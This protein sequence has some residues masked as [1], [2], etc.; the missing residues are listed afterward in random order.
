MELCWGEG[1]G[2]AASGDV[3]CVCVGRSGGWSLW[4]RCMGGERKVRVLGG[5]GYDSR[6]D[7]CFTI[8]KI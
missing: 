2:L 3:G 6:F 5:G 8:R 4:E 1:V 7:E